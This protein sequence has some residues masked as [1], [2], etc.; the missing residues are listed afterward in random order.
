MSLGEEM[1]DWAR[2]VPVGWRGGDGFQENGGAQIGLT[3]WREGKRS[4]QWGCQPW[5]GLD[6]WMVALVTRQELVVD[7]DGSLGEGCREA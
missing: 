6:G 7:V 2:V 3:G 5:G 4:S 1:G